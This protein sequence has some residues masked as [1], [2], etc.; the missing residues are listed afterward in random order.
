MEALQ[1]G[2]PSYARHTRLELIDTIRGITIVSMVLFH[3]TY[4]LV[5]L[6]GIPLPWFTKGPFQEL[7]RCTISWT[8]LFIAGWMCLFSSNNF[9]R[10]VR[11][12]VLAL[13]IYVATTIAA[14]DESINF[15][16]IYC[17][18]ACTFCYYLLQRYLQQIRPDI[19]LLIVVVLFTATRNAYRNVYAAPYLAWLGFPSPGFISG[20][21]YPLIP[22]IFMFLAGYYFGRIVQR[23]CDGDFPLWMQKPHAKPLAL[24]GR[25]PL[26]VYI[27]HQPLLLLI[28]MIV[29]H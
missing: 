11:Y 3:A 4:D 8:F 10:A 19:G 23:K 13:L 28:L 2:K 26:L 16:I 1:N 25:H 14:V 20:D 12:G 18:A 7:W 17:M 24:I 22:F 9:K 29:F 27:V 5:F 21:Y 15:G 6:Y